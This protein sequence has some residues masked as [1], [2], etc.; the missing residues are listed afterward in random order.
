M[1]PSEALRLVASDI[2]P[3]WANRSAPGV[4]VI[5][6]G[7]RGGT[8]AKRPQAIIVRPEEW[9]AQAL[10]SMLLTAADP[11]QPLSSVRTVTQLNVLLRR[12]GRLAGLTMVW[13]A[14]CAR[15]GWA[16]EL[17]LQGLPFGEL[18]ERGRWRSDQSLRI[19]IDTVS[20]MALQ[21]APDVERLQVWIRRFGGPS[22]ETFWRDRC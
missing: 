10:L 19:Y 22:F 2:T 8:K 11:R 21:A 3:S 9:R 6:L 16:T 20:A 14:H 18:R 13:T 4:A 7:V 17:Y 12:A 5:N 1:R 15:A